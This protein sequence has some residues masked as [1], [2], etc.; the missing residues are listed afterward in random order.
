MQRAR[1]HLVVVAT[2]VALIAGSFV[3]LWATYRVPGLGIVAPQTS[4]QNAWTA[5]G[6]TMQLALGL[7]I[8]ATLL[9]GVALASRSQ[10]D[11]AALLA[12]C[13]A[14]LSLLVWQVV[15]GPQGSSNP[16]GYGIDRGLLLFTGAALAAGMTYGSYL[17]FKGNRAGAPRS[18]MMSEGRADRTSLG[19]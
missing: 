18:G 13:A 6:L 19:E 7:A 1:G 8:V 16:N 5:Y 17:A 10:G 3:P 12:L 15:R 14:S 11:G 2:G 9:A 4:H